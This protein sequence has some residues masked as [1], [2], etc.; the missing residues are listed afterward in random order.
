[1]EPLTGADPSA[2][3]EFRVLARLGAGGMGQVYL[4]A[5]P[6]GRFIALKVIQPQFAGDPEFV[7]RFH[8]EADAAQRVSGLYTAPVV[9]AGVDD[10]PPWLATAFVPGP[11]LHE[12]VTAH[13]PLPSAALWRLG[14]GLA[15][16]LR[17]IHSAGLIHRDMKPGNVLLASDGPRVIDFGISRAAAAS[18]RMTATGAAI[19]TPGYMSPEQVEGAEI[20]PASDV[21][22]FG[23]VLAFAASGV[24][25]FAG[26]PGASAPSVMFRVVHGEPA[27]DAVPGDIREVVAA[28][29]AKDPAQRP[30]LGQVAARS[31]A[32]VEYLG[33]SP[34]AFWPGD[35]ASVIDA[36]AA[37]LSQELTT[38]QAGAVAW[39]AP[40]ATVPPGFPGQP[41]FPGQ[42]YPAGQ[43][44]DAQPATP[45]PPQQPF[46][47]Q[48][49]PFPPQPYAPP[50]APG[51]AMPGPMRPVR[52]ARGGSSR[53]AVVISGS[54]A[55]AAA[56]V[57][58]GAWGVSAL[59]SGGK[60]GNAKS[61]S[62][63]LAW[64]FP[65]TQ[66]PN[67]PTVAGKVVYF[68][69]GLS[70]ADRAP[71]YAVH[72]GSG[73]QDWMQT[74][75]MVSVAPVV[76]GGVLTVVDTTGVLYAANA[77]SGNQLWNV[78]TRLQ[79]DAGEKNWDADAAHVAFAPGDGSVLLYPAA[80]AKKAI[81][82]A[83]S[84]SASW[85]LVSLAQ[86]GVV[87]AY[88]DQ[89]GTLA[90]LSVKTGNPVWQLPVTGGGT[91]ASTNLLVAGGAAFIGNQG[92]TLYCVD[93]A[94][95]KLRWHFDVPGATFPA[96][97]L[98]VAGGLVYF[99]DNNGILRAVHTASGR[100][101]WQAQIGNVA[102]PGPAAAVANGHLYVATENDGLQQ[103]DAATGKTG[104]SY[105]PGNA[106]FVTSAA[107]S[108]TTGGG[109]VFVGGDDSA[110]YAI[111]A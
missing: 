8:A 97:G 66:Q 27:L 58:A 12:V 25:P 76:A 63:S 77:A 82:Q 11:S 101:A 71:L 16:A 96:S 6:A 90:A 3:R 43:F 51:P 104:W 37:A 64:R 36:Q 57:G 69:T 50:A 73:R 18:S 102:S 52:P 54:I 31:A 42:G 7:R 19:G 9:A 33:L 65:A 29:L 34:A 95:R 106:G 110:M 105:T 26:A 79:V 48:A 13:G 23:S 49:A 20:S 40:P 87:Y 80:T 55:G 109:L 91:Q 98:T 28:C 1:V 44:P 72:T 103:F 59:A 56:I 75:N 22:S 61:G 62:G 108:S 10:R 92:G 4:A 41:T 32:A 46:P 47:Q 81:W 38:L 68:G 15:E 74:P 78:V 60:P 107:V 100:Q 88:D 70:G 45:Y 2:V 83:A 53:R 39:Q 93:T 89:H 24:S 35:V 21:F 84:A 30:D 86:A 14:A 94:G 111:R 17:A 67:A 5:S 99:T 85:R